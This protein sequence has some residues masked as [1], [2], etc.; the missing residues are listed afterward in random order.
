MLFFQQR[1]VGQMKGGL[2][3]LDEEES[4]DEEVEEEKGV[5]KSVK[6]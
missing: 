1:W 4:E 6:R 2:R 5:Q 3:D